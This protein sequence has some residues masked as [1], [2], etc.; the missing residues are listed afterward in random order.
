MCLAKLWSSSL[1]ELACRKSLQGFERPTQHKRCK[2]R[3]LSKNW[4]SASAQMTSW[5][6]SRRV[7]SH[8]IQDTCRVFHPSE[9]SGLQK[10][11]A[12]FLT[13]PAFRA[14]KISCLYGLYRHSCLPLSWVQAHNLQGIW[15]VFLPYETSRLL[16][17]NLS[18]LKLWPS[19]FA[20][21]T[22]SKS[23]EEFE[24]TAQRL[25]H[26]ALV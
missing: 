25:W 23:L 21:A 19:A 7:W 16:S 15:Q 9:L 24:H 22:L 5:K 14:T 4:P 2:C 26:P 17:F 8:N 12:S 18:T 3:N 11:V 1:G 6:W 10:L 13:L 20:Q